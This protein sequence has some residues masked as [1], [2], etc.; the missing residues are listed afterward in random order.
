MMKTVSLAFAAAALIAGLLAAA[1][2][3]SAS[4]LIVPIPMETRTLP[5]GTKQ[6]GPVDPRSQPERWF[7][8]VQLYVSKSGRLNATAAGWTALAVLLSGLSSICAALSN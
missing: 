1:Y 4:R 7:E 2:W 6:W 5:S 3:W 8:T